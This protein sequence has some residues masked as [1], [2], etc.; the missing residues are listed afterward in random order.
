MTS[1]EWADEQCERQPERGVRREDCRRKLPAELASERADAQ[2]QDDGTR[3]EADSD[4]ETE[5][6]GP[7]GRTPLHQHGEHDAEAGAVQA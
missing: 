2:R 5:G 1:C 4:E 6:Y 3:E 7:P